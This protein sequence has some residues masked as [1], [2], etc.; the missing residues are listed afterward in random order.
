MK[1][2]AI[3]DKVISSIYSS[4]ILDRFQDIDLVISC[5]D[6]SY[7]YLEF[8]ISSL[9]VPLYYV[10]GNHAQVIEYGSAGP[11][12]CP[13]GAVDLHLKTVHDK[14]TDLLMAGIQGSL[15]YRPGPYQYSQAHMFAMVL[16]LAPSLMFN[17]IRYGRFLDLFITH[18]P[19]WSI[20]DQNDL[21]HQ[22][23]KAFNWL[24]KTFQPQYHL[25]GHIHVY[26]PLM[27]TET[28]VGNTTVLNSF[29]YRKLTLSPQRS[30]QP[31][32]EKL[33]PAS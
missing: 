13:W 27:T 19:P 29:G 7:Y 22:G 10:R 33:P 12:Q 5:G 14:E 9:D 6:L 4:T 3:S 8:I 25:H 21:P 31:L 17:K 11:R 18:A 28:Q 20:H 16:K 26:N 23:I 15:R 2:L 24:I 32:A 1:L 30:L